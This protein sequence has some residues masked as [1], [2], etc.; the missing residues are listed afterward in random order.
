M[1]DSAAPN[2]PPKKAAQNI[3]IPKVSDLT[4]QFSFSHIDQS[5]YRE[6][7]I[8]LGIAVLIAAAI[9]LFL[10]VGQ[11]MSVRREI[12]NTPTTT[13]QFEERQE[14]FDQDQQRKNDVVTINSALKAYQIKNNKPPA[15]LK[16]LVPSFLNELPLDPVTN[17]EYAY[18]IADDKKTWEVSTTLSDKKVF[19]VKGP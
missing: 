12:K 17:G 19:T 15:T 4:K 11:E 9:W 10:R 5:T 6:L 14:Q 1:E 3:P 16:E 7:A 13:N 18:K 2:E 8:F